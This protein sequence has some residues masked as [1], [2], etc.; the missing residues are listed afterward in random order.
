LRPKEGQLL[1]RIAGRVL[2]ALAFV[3][4]PASSSAD[5]APGGWGVSDDFHVPAISIDESFDE[6]TPSS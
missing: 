5:V 1:G 6:L 2:V 3:A 4:V